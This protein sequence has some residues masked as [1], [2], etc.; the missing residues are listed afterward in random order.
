MEAT[1]G[2]WTVLFVLALAATHAVAD[3]L[4]VQSDSVVWPRWQARLGVTNTTQPSADLASGIG[5]QSAR[6]FGDYYFTG[7]G[8]G[9]GRVSGGLRATSG[10]LAGRTGMLSAPTLPSAQGSVFSLS[11]RRLQPPAMADAGDPSATMPYLGVGY[12][13]VSARGGWGFTADIGLM[14]YGS[15]GGL[16]F[17][18]TPGG[19]QSVDDL[20]RE[21]RMTP[22]LQ[23]GVSYSF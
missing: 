10:L 12:T 18:H 15:G 8:F 22:V 21:L 3:G 7:P 16:R 9:A 13:G 14:G 17:G 11:T 20:L 6:L 23:L 1:E 5:L 4:N 19:T 2:R